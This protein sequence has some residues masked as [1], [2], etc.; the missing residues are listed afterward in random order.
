MERRWKVGSGNVEDSFV[1]PAYGGC[2]ASCVAY[3]IDE[4][5]GE[6]AVSCEGAGSSR[7]FAR[8]SSARSEGGIGHGDRFVTAGQ[9]CGHVLVGEVIWVVV[10]TTSRFFT[11]DSQVVARASGSSDVV[12]EDG[13]SRVS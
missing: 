13:S 10:N 5:E 6:G 12:C 11:V 9:R 3:V 1:D 7:H 4:G 2:C 8:S